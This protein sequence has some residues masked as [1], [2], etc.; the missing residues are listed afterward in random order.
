LKPSASGLIWQSCAPPLRCWACSRSSPYWLIT[1]PPVSLRSAAW[2]AKSE[3]T[4]ADVI[5]YVRRY[6]WTHTEF[7]HS[8]AQSGHVPISNAVLQGLMDVLCYAA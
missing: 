7:V 5:A 8:Q 6:L 3:A 4:F 2:Y 1:S